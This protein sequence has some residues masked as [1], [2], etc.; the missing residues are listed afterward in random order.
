MHFVQ[1]GQ[2]GVI[3]G[4]DTPEGEHEDIRERTPSL[5]VSLISL[6]KKNKKKKTR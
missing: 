1:W 6:K 3:T 2:Y 5:T 4:K